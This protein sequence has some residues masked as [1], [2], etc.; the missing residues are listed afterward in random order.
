MENILKR[1]G[2]AYIAVRSESGHAYRPVLGEELKE[3]RDDGAIARDTV[4][5]LRPD[6]GGECYEYNA[7]E[8]LSADIGEYDIT[9]PD[10]GRFVFFGGY[11][12]MQPKPKKPKPVCRIG[13]VV[14]WDA[15]T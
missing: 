15:K 12:T 4:L 9:F 5:A 13:T 2:K 7:T 1:I 14:N 10:S 6:M 3:M 8:L 11:V